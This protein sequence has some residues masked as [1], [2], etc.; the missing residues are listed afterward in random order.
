[1]TKKSRSAKAGELKPGEVLLPSRQ[2][3][4]ADAVNLNGFQHREDQVSEL[5]S[6]PNRFRIRAFYINPVF[7]IMKEHLYRTWIPLSSTKRDPI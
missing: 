5:L 7:V 6:C 3:D 2:P 4:D 1:M